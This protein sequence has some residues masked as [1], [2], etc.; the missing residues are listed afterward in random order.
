MKIVVAGSRNINIF[1]VKWI[2]E[3]ITNLNKT[4]SI[5]EIVSGTAIGVD[6]VGETWA[7]LRNIPIKQFTANW[8]IGKHAGM[9]R[10]KDMANYADAALIFWDGNSPGTKQMIAYLNEIKKKH[11]LC[12]LKMR[13]IKE[14]WDY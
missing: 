5:S 3:N 2:T 1:D 6:H 10:N 4:V 9:L 13:T 7:K 8:S 12:D 11:W 14:Y